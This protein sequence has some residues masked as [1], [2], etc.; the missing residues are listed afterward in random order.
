MV[1]PHLLDLV[2]G[3]AGAA[4]DV[5]A[6]GVGVLVTSSFAT[7]RDEEAGDDDV[8]D[9]GGGGG[10]GGG[11]DV[12]ELVDGVCWG[13][14]NGT[15]VCNGLLVSLSSVVVA[16]GAASFTTGAGSTTGATGAGTGGGTGLRSPVTSTISF[17]IASGDA[18]SPLNWSGEAAV[19]VSTDNSVDRSVYADA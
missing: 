19:E 16:A 4:A 18:L 6:V 12:V 14:V 10:G 2:A 5:V 11:E 15:E 17:S 3:A 9:D 8:D 1:Q 7:G 13:S